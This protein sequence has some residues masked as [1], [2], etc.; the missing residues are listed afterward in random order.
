MGWEVKTCFV[1][2][3]GSQRNLSSMEP[4][5]GSMRGVACCVL[6]GVSSAQKVASSTH[7]CGLCVSAYLC[8][9]FSPSVLSRSQTVAWWFGGRAPSREIPGLIRETRAC[10]L[11]GFQPPKTRPLAALSRP[12]RLRDVPVCFQPAKVSK[13][14]SRVSSLER[15]Q[16]KRPQRGRPETSFPY[17][18]IRH[19]V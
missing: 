3:A 13:T 11:S 10:C 12:G 15:L 7:T 1:G 14:Q 8:P 19:K 6:Y 4:Q 5:S 17:E 16:K 2:R 9:D 18:R